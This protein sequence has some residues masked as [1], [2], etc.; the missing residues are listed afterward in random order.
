MPNWR[1]V[2]TS[3]SAANFSS[4]SVDT[5][6]TASIVSSSQFIGNLSGTASYATQALSA[7]YAPG[8]G[9]AAFP[10]TGSA[11]ITGSLGVTGSVGLSYLVTSAAA[12]SAGGAMITARCSLAG[13]GTNT[14]ALAFGG[15]TLTIVACTEAY[16]GT[17]WS[18]GGVLS[19]ARYRL[20]GAG[21][22]TA[23]LAFGG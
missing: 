9:G 3:G 2:T 15:A 10:Y 19:T 7:S 11:Q 4:L 14:A 12:W 1:K 21:T 17:S 22:N 20:A 5:S 6:I 16:N 23:A 18:A 13:A 8:G